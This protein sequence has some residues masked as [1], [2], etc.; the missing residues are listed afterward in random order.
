SLREGGVRRAAGGMASEWMRKMHPLR[1]QYELLSSHN[2]F[3]S[4]LGPATAFAHENRKI[5]S[6]DNPFWQAQ[7]QMSEC[8]RT[9]LDGYRDVRDQMLEATFRVVYTSPFLQALV[10]LKA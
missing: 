9:A 7:E 8:I 3:L 10:G 2:P 1:L 5:V 4:L 6:K